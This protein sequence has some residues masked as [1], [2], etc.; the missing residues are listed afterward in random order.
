MEEIMKKIVIAVL[1]ILATTFT[2]GACD[3]VG[4]GDSAGTSDS[5]T[6]SDSTSNESEGPASDSEDLGSADSS[7]KP[8]DG[9]S[10]ENPTPTTAGEILAAAYSL[11]SGET[12]SGT[13]TLTGTV[14]N[15]KTTGTDEAC[16]TFVVEGYSQYPMYCYW[17]KGTGA[18]TLTVGDEI[19][20]SGTI[21]NYN[22]TV[23]FDHPNLISYNGG[24]QGG[25]GGGSNDGG[26]TSYTYTD[27][28]ADEKALFNEYFGFVI[29]FIPTNDYYVEEYEYEE[30]SGIT[31]YTYGNTSADF[32]AYKAL[33]S[34]RKSVV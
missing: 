33:F 31:F 25:E 7:E 6:V 23:E 9:G 20:V 3:F 24:N 21:K 28:T 29:P 12:L 5:I 14:T 16:L 2:F 26:D 17:L 1:S 34:D 8:D 30:E 19:T 10:T 4:L 27:F 32:D 18:G 15:V 13:Y 22:G 11:K